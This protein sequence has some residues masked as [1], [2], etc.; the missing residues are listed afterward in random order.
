MRLVAL[1]LVIFIC[2]GCGQE[3]TKE[4]DTEI[5]GGKAQI[6][7]TSP[8]V[9]SYTKNG[10]EVY[11]NFANGTNIEGNKVLI[12]SAILTVVNNQVTW[13]AEGLS[14]GEA[15]NIVVLWTNTDGSNGS[16]IL[17]F[18]VEGEKEIEENWY[19]PTGG[20]N[21]LTGNVGDVEP[22]RTSVDDYLDLYEKC[23]I[24]YENGDDTKCFSGDIQAAG[25]AFNEDHPHCMKEYSERLQRLSTKLV[26][27]EINLDQYQKE[28]LEINKLYYKCLGWSG[29]QIERIFELGERIN[30]RG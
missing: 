15:N 30:R 25:L 4:E 17:V 10:T 11:I 14:K 21:P 18:Y 26:A 16:H 20:N 7:S 19:V 29:L 9:G 3:V 24:A 2:L 8:V 5:T 6:I 1:F 13:K 27:G 28:A 12:S 23:V 22:K